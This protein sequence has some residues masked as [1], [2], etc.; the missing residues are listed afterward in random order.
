MLR[1]L[2]CINQI[3]IDIQINLRLQYTRTFSGYLDVT[4]TALEAG[5]SRNR[6]S[7]PG[8]CWILLSSPKRP[9]RLW[10]LHNLLVNS[11][12]WACVEVEADRLCNWSLKFN[13]EVKNK[14]SCASSTAYVFMTYEDKYL[15]LALRSWFSKIVSD[16]HKRKPRLSYNFLLCT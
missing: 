6:G 9:D 14:R 10:C 1:F 4:V 11:H 2:W 3:F 12:R 7:I 5:Q 13:A 8:R 16:W 15:P